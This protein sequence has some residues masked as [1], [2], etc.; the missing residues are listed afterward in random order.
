MPFYLTIN[1]QKSHSSGLYKDTLFCGM[2]FISCPGNIRLHDSNKYWSMVFSNFQVFRLF[3]P[4][5][6][7]NMSFLS[8][9]LQFHTVFLNWVLLIFY[10]CI[11]FTLPLLLWIMSTSFLCIHSSLFT[12]KLPLFHFQPIISAEAK[13]LCA[14]PG[15]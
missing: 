11:L 3:I 1:F 7:Y 8:H 6:F 10:G 14:G 15:Y 13:L 5:A 12:Y 4:T 2:L 9:V